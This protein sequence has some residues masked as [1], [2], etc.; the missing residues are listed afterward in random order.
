MA[1]LSI[2]LIHSLYKTKSADRIYG[3]PALMGLQDSAQGFN[4][5]SANLL[6]KP[7]RPRRHPSS[8][9]P[10]GTL[11]LPPLGSF[12][13]A[14]VHPFATTSIRNRPEDVD[15]DEDDLV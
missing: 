2:R 10:N 7:N 14:S 11:E 13:R 1:D 4:P 9:L 8:S 5:I 15:E 3:P 12:L 6:P